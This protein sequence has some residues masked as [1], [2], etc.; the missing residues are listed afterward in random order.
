MVYK[1]GDLAMNQKALLRAVTFAVAFVLWAPAWAQVHKCVDAR[2]KVRYQDDPCPGT[3]QRALPPEPAVV[4]SSVP[5]AAAPA[6]GEIAP[7]VPDQA[8]KDCA[9]RWP[10][11]KA[12]PDAMR[13]DFLRN[14]SRFGFVPPDSAQQLG[15]N[16]ALA[17]RLL[18][19][20][21]SNQER[22]MAWEAEQQRAKPAT[23]TASRPECGQ[24]FVDIAKMRALLAQVPGDQQE[25][26]RLEIDKAEREARRNCP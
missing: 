18:G 2:G 22:R 3:V 12:A 26:A 13:A 6:A 20:F 17:G 1:P 19:A 4:P 23:Q 21:K 16:D 9:E 24:V 25:A 7:P 14:C 5:A 15:I 10:G 8:S 11:V